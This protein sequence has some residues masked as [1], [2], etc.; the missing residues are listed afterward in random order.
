MA[1]RRRTNPKVIAGVE[2][3]AFGHKGKCL[4]RDPEGRVVLV[5]G[6]APGDRATVVGYRKRK[7]MLLTQVQ[8]FEK[9]SEHRTDPVCKHFGVCG[10]CKWQHVQY[11]E[12]LRQKQSVIENALARIAKV[13]VERYEP[14]LGA[15]RLFNYR[16]KM[17]Y[18]C[19]NQRWLTEDEIQR[20]DEI[21]RDYAIGFH[22]PGAWS[23]IVDIDQC[24]LQEEP[25][26][27]IRNWVREY[28]RTHEIS[29][30]DVYHNQGMLRSLMIRMNQAGDIMLIAVW[31]SDQVPGQDDFFNEIQ[32]AFP[33]IISLYSVFNHKV[34]D[35]LYDLDFHLIAGK[36]QII[37]TLGERQYVI[38][39][40][41]FFQT[42]SYQAKNLYDI[43]VEF[44]DLH[45]DEVIYDLYTGT[46]SI[47]CYLAGHAREVIGVETIADAIADAKI[48]AEIN[49]ITN[50]SFYVGDVEK[51][52]TDT[53][54]DKHGKPDVIIL[55]PPRV[56][57]HADAMNFIAG[58][59]APRIVYVSCN[60]ATQARDLAMIKDKYRVVRSQGVDM[61]PHT[62]HI[63]N[64]VECI[65]K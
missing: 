17:E 8:E 22:R 42:N 57:V 11:E 61:F 52:F 24:H 54:I 13:E 23:K 55:D 46:G 64:V 18:S 19:S 49:N 33:E 34:N 6:G 62:D 30:Y 43:V 38:S 20:A 26:N 59:N 56:G 65:L 47:A 25:S 41:S 45:G 58:L 40:K 10:G 50:A 28:T 36:E 44:A 12:Q 53:M 29:M 37:E 9:L 60:P 1:R 32:S 5:E 7:G 31:G 14:I 15:E 63:E 35:S 2:V 51:E 16:N 3:F 48:N 27:A 21:D 39:P 4:G